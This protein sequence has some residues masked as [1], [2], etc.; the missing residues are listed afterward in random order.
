MGLWDFVCF[1]IFSAFIVFNYAY[2]FRAT[3]KERTYLGQE[4]RSLMF[5][6]TMAMNGK[7]YLS[8]EVFLMVTMVFLMWIRAIFLLR[9]NS[10]LGKL[11]G[12]VQTMLSD[13][14]VY[15]FYFLLEVLFWA[16][17]LQLAMH[18]NMR[19]M[20][21]PECYTLLFYAAFGQFDFAI[22]NDFPEFGYYFA[23]AFFVIYLIINI[24]LFLSL[25]TSMVVKL[26]EEFFKNE[27]IYH[28]METLKVRPQTQADKEYSALISL[29]P[30]LNVILFFLAPFLMS[31]KNPEVWNKVILWFAYLPILIVSTTVFLTYNILLLPFCYVKLFFHKIVMIFVYSKSYRVQKA[32]KFI[33]MVIFLPIGPIRLTANVIVDTIAFVRHCLQTDLKK[34]S[35]S[36]Q[37]K[38]FTVESLRLLNKY[39]HERQ[40]RMMPFKQVAS[41]ARDRMGVF[42]QV[43]RLI[44]PWGLINFVQGPAK[45]SNQVYQEENFD[46]LFNK[47]REYS[48]LKQILANNEEMV[49][50]NK[51]RVKSIDCKLMSTLLEDAIRAKTVEKLADDNF[52]FIRRAVDTKERARLQERAAYKKQREEQGHFGDNPMGEAD[53][54]DRLEA[55]KR[56]KHAV[57]KLV[58]LNTSRILEVIGY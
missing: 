11:T 7:T 9:Y 46:E 8:L 4:D 22:L 23:T 38:P 34:V 36:H 55:L 19:Q 48:T 28:I 53:F 29:P 31:S 15:F 13:L 42:Q 10:Y 49:V 6:R 47:V 56:M 54:E 3:W 37:T 41:E 24:G 5:M 52:I 2:L 1:I 45:V 40:E 17:L 25:F 58:Y 30:P 32:D 27:S 35:Q 44:Q 14:A 50:F 12:V 39:V 33:L 18:A 57:R 26:Y 43:A 16:L 20:S 21:L 51:R